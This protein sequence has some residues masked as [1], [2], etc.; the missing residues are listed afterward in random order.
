MIFCTACERTY[1]CRVLGLPHMPNLLS[2]TDYYIMSLYYECFPSIVKNM[3]P[4]CI[5]APRA[6]HTGEKFLVTSLLEKIVDKIVSYCV[7]VKNMHM[8]RNIKIRRA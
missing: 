3:W 1:T 8:Q 4:F 2:G 5:I 7:E 6:L